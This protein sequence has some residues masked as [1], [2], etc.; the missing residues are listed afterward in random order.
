MTLM[1]TIRFNAVVQIDYLRIILC[2]TGVIFL[3]LT[4]H[5]GRDAVT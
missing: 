4:V 2:R 3:A 5:V 1:Q